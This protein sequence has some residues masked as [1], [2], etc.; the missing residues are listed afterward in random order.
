MQYLGVADDV[1]GAGGTKDGDGD[2]LG[3]HRVQEGL[4]CLGGRGWV[5]VRQVDQGDAVGAIEPADF[6]GMAVYLASDAS[7]Y[8][9]GTTLI[10]DG[11]YA[12][13]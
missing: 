9:S 8:H 1:I 5:F 6:G 13:F 10:I 12:I 11:G 2:V 7:R 3:D 4:P